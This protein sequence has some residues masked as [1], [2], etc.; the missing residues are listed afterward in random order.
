MT[1]YATKEYPDVQAPIFEMF[2]DSMGRNAINQ[3]RWKIPEKVVIKAAVTGTIFDREANPNQPYSPDEIVKEAGESFEAG[4]CS[5]HLHVRDEEGN[6]TTERKYY[7]KIIMPLRERYGD[8]VH[9]DGE[10][11]FGETFDASMEPVTAGLLESSYINT[12]ALF[13]G[14]ALFCTPP[15]LMKA[16]C[17]V[18]QKHNCKPVLAVFSL[19]DIDNAFRYLIQPGILKPPY[20]WIF[21]VGLPGFSLV[22]NPSAMIEAIMPF[23]YRIREIDPAKDPFITV[24]GG[25]RSSS[26]VTALGIL[27]GLH[28]RV[29]MEDTIWRWPHKDE[30]VINNKTT[31]EE[32]V[33]MARLLGREPATADDYRKMVGI[34]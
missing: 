16:Q 10:A 7:E 20:E 22:P 24:V 17:E 6:A 32:A 15:S 19:G 27:L 12:T 9:I 13:V 25:G 5:I 29:G 11:V 28:V 2:S 30:I 23:I 3:P 8:K 21:I 1:Q 31:V 4:A 18:I 26:Y 33:A 34:K 14:D